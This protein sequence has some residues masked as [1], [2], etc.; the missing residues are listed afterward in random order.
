[1][2]E[3]HTKIYKSY[4]DRVKFDLGRTPQAD[5]TT[6]VRVV[7]YAESND[8]QLIAMYFQFGRYLLIS[9]SM[10]GT[11]PAPLQGIWNYQMRPSWDGKYTLNINAE[12][13]YWP[14]ELTNLSELHEPFLGLIKDL[15]ETGREAASTMYGSRG[16]T[17]H[18]NT[19]IWRV[20]GAIDRA[21]SGMWPTAGAWLCQHLWDRYLYNGSK[22]YLKSVYPQMKGASQFYLDF[23]VPEPVHGW[24]VVVPSNSPENAPKVFS[25]RSNVFAGCTMDNQMVFDLFF[26]TARAAA[27]VGDDPE[28]IEELNGMRAK[29]A[30]MQI[31][32]YGQLQE[33]MFDWDDPKDDHRHVS[34]LW[35]VY[36]GYQISPYRT[37]LLLQAAKQ[38][39]IYRGDVSTGWSMGWKVNLWARFLDGEHAAKLLR[40][41]LRPVRQ[42]SARKQSGGTYPN[43]F[44]AHPP[45]QIDGNFG[46]T[47]GIAEMLMQS[48]DGAIHLL[49]ALP[50]E[51]ASGKISGLRARG[52]FLLDFEWRNGKLYEVKVKST[53]GG[54]CRLRLHSKIEPEEAIQWA[55]AVGENANSLFPI[56]EVA[57][58][59][60]SP[61]AV[62]EELYMKSYE[63]Y[64]FPTEV[65]KTYVFRASK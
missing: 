52:G 49:P 55:K 50:E 39:L 43:L 34:H 53:V 14:A 36:P 4:Y 5:K 56:Q 44:D 60:I 62:V 35:G 40:D 33:W 65:G 11:Q 22:E 28:F 26:N 21:T 3:D 29:L 9:S 30:P 13:N 24:M 20:S 16:W 32:Q 25:P 8:P 2:V 10:P 58:P 41:Q 51:W 27:I 15:S 6:D 12:M 7:E 59:L 47:A 19:D 42:V 45:F 46:C 54:N 48:H 31:G 18:H 64:D 1:M 23:L 57:N 37:P 17:A 61:K 38:S 63:E